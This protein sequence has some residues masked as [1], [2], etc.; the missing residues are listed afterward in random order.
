MSR[1]DSTLRGH[2]PTETDALAGVL[3][4]YDGVILAPCFFESGRHT[5]DGVHY[6]RQGRSADSAIYDRLRRLGGD[7]RNWTVVSSD[8]A[9]QGYARQEHAQTIDSDTFAR[10][11]TQGDRT[12]KAGS[13]RTEFNSTPEEVNE[14]LEAFQKNPRRGK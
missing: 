14:W 9:V 3:G 13:D 4:P 2:F 11:L 6:V 12:A 10:Q 5:V 8:R 1:S 7:A